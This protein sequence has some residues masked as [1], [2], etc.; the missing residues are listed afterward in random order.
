MSARPGGHG[1]DWLAD[2]NGAVLTDENG[3]V[4][5][6]PDAQIW[7]QDGMTGDGGATTMVAGSASRA[8][9]MA[10]LDGGAVSGADRASG[11]TSGG[12]TPSG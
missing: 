7:W 8:T 3:A 5:T 1:G 6:I 12:S 11:A 10:A 9:G 4:L 2:E